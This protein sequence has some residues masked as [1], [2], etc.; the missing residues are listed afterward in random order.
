MPRSGE[1]V[2]AAACRMDIVRP[3]PGRIY[4]DEDTASAW[5][6]RTERCRGSLQRRYL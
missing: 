2:K 1:E 6:R 3:A 4:E 5:D